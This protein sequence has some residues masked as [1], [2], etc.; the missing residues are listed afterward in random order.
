MVAGGGFLPALRDYSCRADA[1]LMDRTISL[2][3]SPPPP[4]TTSATKICA[5]FQ[6]VVSCV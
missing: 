4:A 5:S 2:V 6:S 3:A 1:E